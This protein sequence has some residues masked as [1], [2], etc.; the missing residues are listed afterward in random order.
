MF[1]ADCEAGTSSADQTFGS[2]PSTCT[3]NPNRSVVWFDHM[4]PMLP[5]GKA[6]SAEISATVLPPAIVPTPVAKVI[7]PLQEEYGASL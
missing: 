7:G 4:T 1:C 2:A 3:Q 5:L 6:V